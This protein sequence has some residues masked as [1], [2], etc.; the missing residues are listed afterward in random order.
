MNQF[1]GVG[2]LG[3]M[4][5]LALVVVLYWAILGRLVRSWLEIIFPVLEK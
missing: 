4:G 2:M 5:E 3:Y 1:I